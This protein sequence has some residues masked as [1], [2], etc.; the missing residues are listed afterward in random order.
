M[1]H[2]ILSAV[3]LLFLSKARQELGTKYSELTISQVRQA[4]SA[5]VESWWQPSLTADA[6]IMEAARRIE[7][8]QRRNAQARKSHTK[9]RMIKFEALGIDM[10]SVQQSRWESG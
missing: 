1:R 6:I 4:T 7:Y 10:L 5:L 9:T 8:Y 3:T 2:L